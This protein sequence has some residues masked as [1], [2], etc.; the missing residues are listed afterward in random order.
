MDKKFV[1]YRTFKVKLP[2]SDSEKNVDKC[3]NFDF[4]KISAVPNLDFELTLTSKF[5][6][7]VFSSVKLKL[8]FFIF[9]VNNGPVNY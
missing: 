9:H 1:F 7:D 5:N 4:C 6:C 2:S 3:E 8:Y